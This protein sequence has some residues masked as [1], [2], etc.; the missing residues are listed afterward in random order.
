MNRAKNL[1]FVRERRISGKTEYTTLYRVRDD[2][3]EQVY[4]YLGQ[5][6]INRE[7]FPWYLTYK[8]LDE[9][10]PWKE[11]LNNELEPRAAVFWPERM[12]VYYVKK[13]GPRELFFIWNNISDIE[14]YRKMNRIEINIDSDELVGLFH[15]NGLVFAVGHTKADQVSR[16]YQLVHEEE[17]PVLIPYVRNYL[18]PKSTQLN[19]CPLEQDFEAVLR[20]PSEKAKGSETDDGFAALQTRQCQNEC[21]SGLV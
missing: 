20:M 19:R 9:I 2:K 15:W 14:W 8:T 16:V 4:H 11:L 13:P 3:I 18:C 21:P 5:E 10:F 12:H 17:N 1:I 7:D 6:L